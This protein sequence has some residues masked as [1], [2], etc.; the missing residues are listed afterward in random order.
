MKMRRSKLKIEELKAMIKEIAREEV[1]KATTCS[2]CGRKVW[3]SA[4]PDCESLKGKT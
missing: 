2:S 4:G 3:Q 1:K